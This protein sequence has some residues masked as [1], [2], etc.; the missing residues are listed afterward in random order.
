MIRLDSLSP[1]GGPAQHLPEITDHCRP[2]GQPTFPEHTCP[3][4]DADNTCL[5]CDEPIDVREA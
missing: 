5:R 1:V 2:M 3:D 4:D